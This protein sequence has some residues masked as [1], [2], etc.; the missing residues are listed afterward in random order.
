MPGP[1]SLPA[2]L[3]PGPLDEDHRLHPSTGLSGSRGG[4]SPP[5]PGASGLASPGDSDMEMAAG[6]L[7]SVHPLC[8]FLLG[9]CV[10][11]IGHIPPD[12]TDPPSQ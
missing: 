8:L 1:R 11:F 6:S 12:Y 3:F 5:L 10:L 9:C 4:P 2:L 7:S